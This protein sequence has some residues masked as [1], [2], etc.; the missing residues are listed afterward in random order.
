MSKS[1]PEDKVCHIQPLGVNRNCMFIVD[2]DSVSC[3]D[4]KADN[5]GSWKCNGTRPLYFRLNRKNRP[6]FL[7]TTPLQVAG[8]YHIIRRYSVHLSNSNFQ[9]CIVEIRGK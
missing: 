7:K 3:V 9:Q 6:E 4:L 2:L 5:T 1:R 8:D